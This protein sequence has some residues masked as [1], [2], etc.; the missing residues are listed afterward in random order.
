MEKIKL[1][2]LAPY[3]PYELKMVVFVR[4]WGNNHNKEHIRIKD[5]GIN[6]I[7]WLVT[8]TRNKPILRPLSDLKK[9]MTDIDG[10]FIPFDYLIDNTKVIICENYINKNISLLSIKYYDMEKLFQ[11][12]FDV[13]GLIEKGLAIDINTLNQQLKTK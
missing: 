4:G 13:F 12:H 6:Q 11:W 10:V 1:K 3:L 9:P 2:H 7:E 8:S 5:V